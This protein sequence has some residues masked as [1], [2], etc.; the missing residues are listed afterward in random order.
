MIQRYLITGLMLLGF[1]PSSK[2]QN[3]I[4]KI[5]DCL[6]DNPVSGAQIFNA[7]GTT[8]GQVNENGNIVWNGSVTFPLFVHKNGYEVLTATDS[9]AMSSL[10]LHPMT[11]DLNEVIVESKKINAADYLKELHEYNVDG[12]HT[13]IDTIVY[14]HYSYSLTIP[15]TGWH[16]D[17]SGYLAH[18][19]TAA[20]TDFNE[21]LNNLYFVQYSY[22][23]T[24]DSFITTKNYKKIKT[25]SPMQLFSY[26]MMGNTF[27]TYGWNL[28]LNP[29]WRQIIFA[30]SNREKQF[31]SRSATDHEYVMEKIGFDSARQL[32]YIET[33]TPDLFNVGSSGGFSK[34]YNY[35]EKN[36][37][38]SFVH[39]IYK[40]STTGPKELIAINHQGFYSGKDLT[41]EVNV[42]VEIVGTVPEIKTHLPI[43]IETN[44]NRSG[45]VR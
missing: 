33:F 37:D 3:G 14:Y 6:S 8:I 39:T 27:G 9:S 35:A 29:Q 30:N 45:Q 43:T 13:V 26:D 40:Y 25:I 44:S 42:K 19:Q 31:K 36:S 5:T 22:Q 7:G 24:A 23:N 34:R 15:G 20:I 1:I 38:R 17:V 11:K 21:F 2:A 41:Y 32:E 12:F 28:I 18:K 4:S 16:E 10:C